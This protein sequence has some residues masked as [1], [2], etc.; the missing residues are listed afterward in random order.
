MRAVSGG[1][2][3]CQGSMPPTAARSA[4][5]FA[6]TPRLGLTVSDPT[7]ERS[8]CKGWGRDTGSAALDVVTEERRSKNKD[9]IKRQV[10]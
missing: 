8:G 6:N 4:A 2:Q 9:K 1:L 7:A 3:V 10:Y 5:A